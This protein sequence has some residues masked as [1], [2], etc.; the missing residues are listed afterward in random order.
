MGQS[1]R[2][3]GETWGESDKGAHMANGEYS[4]TQQRC[5]S[6]NSRMQGMRR[7]GEVL[8]DLVQFLKLKP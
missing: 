5:A 8:H 1:I 4:S 6:I 3:T 7:L 2:Y